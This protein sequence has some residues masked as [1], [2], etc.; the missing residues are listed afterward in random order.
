LWTMNLDQTRLI[1]LVQYYN[2]LNNLGRRHVNMVLDSLRM[3]YRVAL[4]YNNQI[5]ADEVYIRIRVINDVFSWV[6]STI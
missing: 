2:D 4:E 6:D 5:V 1:C 3:S